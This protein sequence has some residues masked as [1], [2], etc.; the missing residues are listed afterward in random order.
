MLLISRIKS[1]ARAGAENSSSYSNSA[2]EVVLEPGSVEVYPS[3]GA[4]KTN[5]VSVLSS[6]EFRGVRSSSSRAP[7]KVSK[8]GAGILESYR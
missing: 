5:L 2:S 6:G 7:G 1:S 4:G 3:E 8:L